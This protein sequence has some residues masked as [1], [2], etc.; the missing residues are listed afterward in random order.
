MT[1]AE[2]NSRR[3]LQAV[4]LEREQIRDYSGHLRNVGPA[5]SGWYVVR[6]CPCHAGRRV[7][8]CLPSALNAYSAIRAMLAVSEK[9]GELA[10]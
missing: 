4:W 10:E 2:H 9:R 1:P 3:W 5:Q 8:V 7:T 6:T